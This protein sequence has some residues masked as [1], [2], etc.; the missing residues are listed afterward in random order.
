M[1]NV[2]E[3]VTILFLAASSKSPS[4]LE[5]GEPRSIFRT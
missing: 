4:R 5:L 1:L 2:M 3:R